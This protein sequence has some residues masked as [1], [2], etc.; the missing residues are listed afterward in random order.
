LRCKLRKELAQYP[1]WST[2][3]FSQS[4]PPATRGDRILPVSHV[5]WNDLGSM[6]WL[7]QVREQLADSMKK[8]QRAQA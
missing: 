1:R 6:R 5:F 3:D 2:K 4:L 7:L 8:Q